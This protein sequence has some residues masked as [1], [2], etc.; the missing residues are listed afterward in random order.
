[1]F[2]FASL[3]TLQYDNINYANEDSS[4]FLVNACLD[5]IVVLLSPLWLIS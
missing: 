1:M 4:Y 3:K 2:L 5:S